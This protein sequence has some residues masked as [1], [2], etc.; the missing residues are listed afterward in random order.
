[1]PVCSKLAGLSVGSLDRPFFTDITFSSSSEVYYG[2]AAE[3]GITSYVICN[4]TTLV[5]R[6]V[7]RR[8]VIHWAVRTHRTGP[9]LAAVATNT[10]LVL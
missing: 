8:G 1:M 3:P 7:E 10:L 4:G 6:H 5:K 2:P 9:S